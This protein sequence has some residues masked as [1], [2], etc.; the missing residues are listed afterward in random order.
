MTRKGLFFRA[1]AL[2]CLTALIMAG[3]ARYER[4]VV[5]FK[6]PGAYPNVIEVAGASVAAEAFSDPGMAGEAF[7]FDIIGAGVLPVQV[8][9]DNRG[10]HPLEIVSD[11]TYLVDRGQNLWPILDANLAYDRIAKKT[12]LGEVAPKAATSGLLGAAGGAIIGAAVGIVT[13]ENVAEA[14]GKGAAVGGAAG[15]VIGGASGVTDHEV[16]R[17]IG[18][19][20]HNRSLERKPVPPGRIAHGFIFFPGESE[21]SLE[22]RLTLLESDTG[23][24]HSLVLAF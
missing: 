11:R 24:M 7:G 6:M 13:G 5:P 21:E 16:R 10:P 3:C 9:F 18:E 14:A 20:L 2:I 8:I 1:A 17:H 19:D 23:T 4:K 12:E 15:A 22:L